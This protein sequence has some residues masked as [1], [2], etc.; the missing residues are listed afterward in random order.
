M[1]NV[2]KQAMNKWPNVPHCFGW[3]ALDNPGRWW[4]RDDAAQA[5]GTP[6]D[7]IRHDGLTSFIARNYMRDA[8]GRWFFQN[9]PQRVFV[10]L[11]YTPWVVQVFPD[12]LKTTTGAAMLPET[13]FMDD[14]GNIL[15]AGRIDGQQESTDIALVSGADLYLI[16]GMIEWNPTFD[17]SDATSSPGALR[18]SDSVQLTIE[19]V[20]ANDMERRFQYVRSPLRLQAQLNMAAGDTI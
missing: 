16:E 7:P 6:G 4:M 11:D 19:R 9:G 17:D 8:Q 14:I 13:C 3:L 5:N 20:Q 15:F 18:W 10:E 2:V 12:S 1:D